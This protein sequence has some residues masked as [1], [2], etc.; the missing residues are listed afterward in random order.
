MWTNSDVTSILLH[1]AAPLPSS[2]QLV[3]RN[4]IPP[5]WLLHFSWKLLLLQTTWWNL[6]FHFLPAAINEV[7]DLRHW[8]DNSPPSPLTICNISNFFS[9]LFFKL[10]F[11]LFFRTFF[12]LSLLCN[13][14]QWVIWTFFVEL[15][16]DLF[17]TFFRTFLSFFRTTS[18]LSPWLPSN[19]F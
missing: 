6:L 10:F 11:E 14:P 8:N 2:T 19:N 1:S 18:F 15:L 9:K 3:S 16:F 5:S 7:D 12:V 17:W 4:K 13:I